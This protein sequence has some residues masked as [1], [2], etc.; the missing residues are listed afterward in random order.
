MK[1]NLLVVER[2]ILEVLCS[3]SL[4]KLK[5]CKETGLD[6]SLVS[7]VLANL[8]IAGVITCCGSKY[9]IVSEKWKEIENEV[10]SSENIKEEVKDLFVSLVNQYFSEKQKKFNLSVKKIWL[11]PFEE[12]I[13]NSHLLNLQ[14]F[15]KNVEKN[16]KYNRTRRSVSEK[17]VIMWGTS[18]YECLVRGTI[19]NIC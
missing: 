13:L 2:M 14:E 15:I 16:E 7:A 3:G 10:N 1:L 18:S 6:I 5:I 9:S 11:D 12:K 4:E 17:K 8:N 19:Q